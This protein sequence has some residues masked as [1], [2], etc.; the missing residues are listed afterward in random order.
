MT[1]DAKGKKVAKSLKVYWANLSDEEREVLKAKLGR[2]RHG[3]LMDNATSNYFYE[4]DL[5]DDDFKCY[6][7][8]D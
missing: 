2:R 5:N 4:G 7:P 3:I 8:E 1:I 6:R